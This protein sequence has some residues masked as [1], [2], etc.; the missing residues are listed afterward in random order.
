MHNPVWTEVRAWD[1]TSVRARLAGQVTNAKQVNKHTHTLTVIKMKSHKRTSF[2]LVRQMWT[3]AASV[4]GR[5]PRSAWTQ[6]V[7]I[8][9][10]AETASGW[11]EMAVPVRA[12][13]LLLHPRC[14][15]LLPPPARNQRVATQMR[16]NEQ[17]NGVRSRGYDVVSCCSKEEEEEGT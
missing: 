11:P 7:A 12:S 10:D 16:V 9:A 15:P 4:G 8:G 6:L 5:A 2:F 13:L 1:P 14:L 17:C 3:S